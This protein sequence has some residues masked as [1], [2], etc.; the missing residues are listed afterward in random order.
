MIPIKLEITNFLSY[1]ETAVLDFRGIHLACIAGANGAGKSSILDAITWALFGQARS[2]SDDDLVN[3]VAARRGEEAAVI[4]TFSLGDHLYRVVRRKRVGK[5][6]ILEFQM[7]DATGNAWRPLTE[8]KMRD[9][10]AAIEKLLRMNYDTFI[11][12]S[13]LLQGKA[14][15]FTTKT[16]GKRKEVLAD[17][18]GV[19][20]WERYREATAEHRRETEGRLQ[21][22]DAQIADIEQELGEEE[23]RKAALAAAEAALAQVAGELTAKE[24][25]LHQ[26]RQAETAVQQTRQ[27]VQEI[28]K[29]LTRA[30]NTL[31]NLRQTYTRQQEELARYQNTLAQAETITSAYVHWQQAEKT[32]KAWQEKAEAWNKLQE[33]RRPHELAVAEAR[34]RL[35]QRQQELMARAEQVGQAQMEEETL[36]A[37]IADQETRLQNI[38]AKLDALTETENALQKARQALQ[39][40]EGERQLW[41]RERTQLEKQATRIGQLQQ[42]KTAVSQNYEQATARL[43][44]VESALNELESLHQQHATT[45]A[46]K[47]RLEEEQP[48]LKEEMNQLRA[49]ID[50]LQQETGQTCP[51]C[52]QP[53]SDEH[54][55]AVVSDLETQGQELAQRYRQ[56]KERIAEMNR[57]VTE[58]AQKLRDRERLE[59]DRK[60]QQQRLAQAEARLTEIENALTEWEATGAG[61]LAELRQLLADDSAVLAR[62]QQVQELETALQPKVRLEK[63]RRELE[64]T[65][66]Q[67]QAR[68]GEVKRLITDWEERGKAE[69]AT[70][71]KQLAH[72]TY[73][74]DAQAALAALD[75]E[76]EKL[77]YD[78]EAHQQAREALAALADIPEQYQALQRAEAAIKPLTDALVSLE[79]QIS[80]QEQIIADLKQQQET[81]ESRLATLT[82]ETS[83]MAK[84]EAEV[85]RLR[86]EQVAANQRVGAARQRLDVL[87]DLRARQKQLQKDRVVLTQRIQRLRI[88]EKACGKDGVQ[89]LLIEQALPEI[90]ERANELLDRLTGGGMR[91]NFETQRQL[92]SR[93]A[94]AETLDI[95]IIDNAGERPYTNY[96]GGE[97]F[98]INFAIRLALSQLLARRAGA[99]LRT[100]VIDEG[101]GSQDPEGRQRLVEAIN[102]IQNEFDCI[103]VITHVDELRDAFPVRI[104]VEKTANGSRITVV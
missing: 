97:Q 44:E 35:E 14:D 47:N 80:D 31:Q 82:S 16:P 8:G 20:V 92:K 85:A 63:E 45:L 66:A 68:L 1:R 33:K 54:R 104:E 57:A 15:E 94:L 64:Q 49:R 43:A 17:L 52:G 24:A 21:I 9:T 7:L 27:R 53:L 2:K 36:I 39:A 72:K 88:L 46:D 71:Q 75:E 62:R 3:R 61:R 13:F 50:Q 99:S 38:V 37:Q 23:A 48:R 58:M 90:E 19:T 51:L 32:L 10:Q 12:A 41:E 4:F 86:E 73:A 65:L 67:A 18:L 81:A 89:A 34:S 40:L 5:T 91:V 42:E 100:L 102:V 56:N 77:G 69:L 95:R 101:F 11:N 74:P 70:V 98:R 25:L 6:T 78:P 83:Q 29:S 30:Q 76:A 79:T 28:A 96:S 93:D 60:T 55:Q 84:L 87:T 26:M 22:L 59:R 103:L